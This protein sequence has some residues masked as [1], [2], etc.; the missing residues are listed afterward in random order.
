MS[1]TAILGEAWVL[2]KAHWRHLLPIAFV[3]YLVLSLFTLLL[4]L[5]LG[6][7]GAIAGAFV[8]LA[9]TFW[10]QGALVVAIEDVRD[11]R[12]DLSIS[13]T[14]SRV[15]P[16]MNPL[17]IG[18]ILASIGITIGFILLI[19]PGLVL[20][21]WWL[22]IVPV[23]MLEGQSATDAFGRS[24]EL[25]RGNGWNVFG[26]IVLTIVILIVA[27]IIIGIILLFLPDE[28]GQYVSNVIANTLF[29]PF[30]AAAWTLAYYHLRDAQTASPPGYQTPNLD[31]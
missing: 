17:A 1:P 9:G 14:L 5:L 29:S 21:T 3:V 23:I 8:S 28:V 19:V 27:G 13:E 7:V 11:G 25:V 22:F 2:Y 20:L 26:L 12:A 6:W 15:R 16:R 24:R 31:A 4:A 18:G 10:L 30:V